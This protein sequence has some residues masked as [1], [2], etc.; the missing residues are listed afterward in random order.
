MMTTD[1]DSR[2]READTPWDKAV[3]HPY[4]QRFRPRSGER[5]RVLVPGCG[6]GHDAAALAR[7]FP[8]AE[9]IGID[10]SEAALEQAALLQQPKNVTLRHAD[11]FQLGDEWNDSID[12]VWEHTC[13]CAIEPA[14]R[15]AYR[16]VMRRVV[17]RGGLLIGAFFL[18]MEESENGG[19]PFNTPPE[20]FTEIFDASNGFR[21]H[22]KG[23]MNPTFHGR[24][25][26]EWLVMM[27]RRSDWNHELLDWYLSPTVRSRRAS[28]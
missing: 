11:I 5:I 20:E 15:I 27:S 7:I 6:R 13:F 26:E 17:K 21:I 8:A 14:Q 4:L 10:I 3:Q 18:T 23:L 12:F 2:Y 9:V 19:P 28:P 16:E 24:E 25:G 22:K 1:W